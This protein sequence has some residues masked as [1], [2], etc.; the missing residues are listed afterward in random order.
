MNDLP[1]SLFSDL[2]VCKTSLR[3]SAA[4]EAISRLM[5]ISSSMVDCFKV[6]TRLFRSSR[7]YGTASW[8]LVKHSPASEPEIDSPDKERRVR[9]DSFFRQEGR[10]DVVE[11]LAHGDQSCETVSSDRMTFA[12]PGLLDPIPLDLIVLMRTHLDE[13]KISGGKFFGSRKERRVL[14]PER[15]CF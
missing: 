8:P 10:P 4:T 9:N 12:L 1:Y 15:S 6:K 2:T 7:E 14:C 5:A 3:R 11:L 13:L